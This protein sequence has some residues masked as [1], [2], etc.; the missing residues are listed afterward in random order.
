ME[1]VL[2]TI[3]NTLIIFTPTF[4]I[5]PKWTWLIA[6]LGLVCLIDKVNAK[7]LGFYSKEF[8]ISIALIVISCILSVLSPI[9]H[10]TYDFVYLTFLIGL[11]LCIFRGIFLVYIYNRIFKED[12]KVNSYLKYFIYSCLIY[13]GFTFLF[14][15][16]PGF[17]EF[18]LNNVIYP[19]PGPDYIAY[20]F[21][22][23]LDGFAAFSSA[24]IFSIALLINSY[25]L[26]SEESKENVIRNLVTYIV[27][28]SGCFIYGRVTVFAIIL[29]I[30]YII[31][32]C[33]DKDKLKKI[34]LYLSITCVIVV[35]L[36]LQLGKYNED[37]KIWTTWAFEIVLNLFS[38]KLGDSYSFTHMLEDMYFLPPI[39][40][41]L[42]G[43]GWYTNIDGVG[44]YMQTDV[45]FLR[46]ILFF[47]IFGLICNFSA[48]TIL[49]NKL[50]LMFNKENNK[51]GAIL[52]ISIFIL[53]MI[54]ELKGE[55]F[56]RV[57]YCMLPLYF[58]QYGR[59]ESK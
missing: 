58:I 26:I 37:I 31:I 8:V 53:W 25:L 13:V 49:L 32:C 15:I 24:S 20:K 48:V 59:E 12:A 35:I 42:L 22:Y 54:L 27:I 6:L 14:I 57:M 56:H 28:L 17:K 46:P 44:Y 39:K 21:R 43:D 41:I 16:F 18:W 51:P 10:K 1:R 3:L 40:T 19:I 33:K 47:G 29:S 30:L 9:I 2:F 23:S 55:T 36:L 4:K 50:R 45:G 5:F 34:F 38:G 7:K 52:M 11:L